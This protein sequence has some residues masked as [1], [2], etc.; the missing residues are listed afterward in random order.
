MAIH[1]RLQI[2]VDVRIVKAEPKDGFRRMEGLAI[3]RI[4]F[5]YPPN[6][7]THK[8]QKNRIFSQSLELRNERKYSTPLKRHCL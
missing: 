8:G 2:K 6:A 5:R 3:R 1:C 7:P 4:T